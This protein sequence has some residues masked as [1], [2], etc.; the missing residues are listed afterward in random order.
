MH[1]S[2]IY[3]S[4]ESE[5]SGEDSTSDDS[6][7]LAQSTSLDHVPSR[8]PVQ[9]AKR[10]SPEHLE[11]LAYM[12][13]SETLSTRRDATKAQKAHSWSPSPKPPTLRLAASPTKP[14]HQNGRVYDA[15]IETRHFAHMM[16]ITCLKGKSRN[17]FT[18]TIY[19]TN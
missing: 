5:S 1:Q 3:Q 17:A 10:Y 12:M 9:R 11:S 19:D 2:L 14:P 13:A 16:V 4:P 15:T 7:Y 8:N 18:V 6:P